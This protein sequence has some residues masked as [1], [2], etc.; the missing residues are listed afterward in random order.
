MAKKGGL[1]KGLDAILP[2]Q[3]LEELMGE[4]PA[5]ERLREISLD[6]ISPNPF[7]PRTDLDEN[8][9][10]ELAAS[11]RE[12]GVLQPIIVTQV[13]SGY[14]LI[15][16]ERRWRASTIAG[17]KTIPAII[18]D[19][20]PSD[21][22]LLFMALVENLQRVNLDPIEE[23]EAYQTLANKFSLSQDEIAKKMGKSRP[24]VTNSIRLLKLPQPV[25]DLL[26]EKKITAG[27]A[28]VLL[29]DKDST[30]QIRLAQMVARRGLSVERLAILITGR[31]KI[32]K[33]ARVKKP[34]AILALEEE[35]AMALGTRVEIKPGK[36]KGKLIIEY[37][38]QEDL[39][40][41]VEKLVS[42]D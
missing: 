9:L 7:Q 40:M 42:E 41:L 28:K 2:A 33:Q 35:I 37:Y 26:R 8:E 38:S 25:L 5:G 14:I 24:T 11:I 27:H 32:K 29:E 10:K 12:Q 3:I 34:A 23:A 20:K 15:A 19:K 22:Q 13:E 16:G 31:K 18:L 6:E 21:E 39:A 36:K 4:V 17:L 1:G 30:R